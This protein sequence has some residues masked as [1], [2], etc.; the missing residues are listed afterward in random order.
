MAWLTERSTAILTKRINYG[1]KTRYE[2]PNDHPAYDKEQHARF[3]D[4]AKAF[5]VPFLETGYTIT[6]SIKDGVATPY[7][8]SVSKSGDTC[9]L[10]WGKFKLDLQELPK[11]TERAV[12]EVAGRSF[13]EVFD[14]KTKVL[15]T[16][17]MMLSKEAK[18]AKVKP[19]DLRRTY[20][21]EGWAGLAKY[22]SEGGGGWKKLADL[23]PGE[24]QVTEYRQDKKFA[25][26]YELYLDG[27]GWVKSNKSL[28]SDLAA[29]P[30]ITGTE[31][32]TLH[33]GV[34]TS[35]YNGHPVVPTR[36]ITALD[37]TLPTFEIGGGNS[38]PFEI[39]GE[40]SYD[41]VPY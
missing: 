29:N 6:V 14:T 1:D 34:S 22:L 19:E 20:R 36:L 25:G 26:K 24:Y 7:A 2:V 13:I 33:I 32:A 41:E 27:I 12:V 31:P 3:N 37:L 8:P 11:T 4:I 35:T 9:V 38:E 39:D 21:M 5:G 40:V 28:A 17:S 30:I 16:V 10:V 15:E 18:E 23:Q